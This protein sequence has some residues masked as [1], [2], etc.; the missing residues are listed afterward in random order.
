MKIDDVG[1]INYKEI[2]QKIIVK[3]NRN[4]IMI[5]IGINFSNDSNNIIIL[6]LT[7]SYRFFSSK[8]SK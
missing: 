1:F 5:L 6:F 4:G 2:L 7:E 8:I 3:Q